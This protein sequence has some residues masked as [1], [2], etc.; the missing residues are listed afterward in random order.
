MPKLTQREPN[1]L[2]RTDG[3]T[4]N[5]EKLLFL[6]I[7][8]LN[9]I[10]FLNSKIKY[11][12]KNLEKRLIFRNLIRIQSCNVCK[13]FINPSSVYTYDGYD[14]QLLTLPLTRYIFLQIKYYLYKINVEFKLIKSLNNH[15]FPI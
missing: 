7:V 13:L 5:V 10:N 1:C 9:E 14:L 8:S 3:L 12:P 15:P 11:S 4:L 2:V 6:K